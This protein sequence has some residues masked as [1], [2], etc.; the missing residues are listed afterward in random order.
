MYL[1]LGAG[2]VLWRNERMK[3]L[4]YDVIVKAVWIIFSIIITYL[5]LA[6]VFSTSFLGE[7][8]IYNSYTKEVELYSG[9]TFFVR[10]AWWL[11]LMVFA[12]CTVVLYFA[13]MNKN[14]QHFEW[15]CGIVI[16]L[17]ML[18][19]LLLASTEPTSDSVKMLRVV[20]EFERGDYSSFE[21]DQY[22]FRYPFQYGIIVFYQMLSQIFGMTNYFAFRFF[23]LIFIILTYY[24]LLKI[25]KLVDG[26]QNIYPFLI[27]VGMAFTPYFFYVTLIYGNI[28][29]FFFSVCSFYF[30][31]KYDKDNN[32]ISIVISILTI[33]LAIIFKSNCKIFF[34]AEVLILCVS[35]LKDRN[36]KKIV[37]QRILIIMCFL[38]GV[39][40]S[41]KLIEHKITDLAGEHVEG[42]PM[43]TWVAMGLCESKAAPGWYNGLSAEL[44]SNNNFEYEATVDDSLD[45]I[46]E[47]IIRSVKDPGYA[48]DFYSRKILSMWNNPQFS[49]LEMISSNSGTIWDYLFKNEGRYIYVWI[50]NLIHTWILI[51][52]FLYAVLSYKTISYK[53]LLLPIS[54]VGGFVFHI[55]WEAKCMYAMPYV[56]LMLPLSI[57]GYMKWSEW[58]KEYK[59]KKRLLKKG[60]LLGVTVVCLLSYTEIFTRIIARDDDT[61]RYD[62]YTR[63]RVIYDREEIY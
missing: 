6:S 14:Y 57:S 32:W 49:S 19:L 47:K 5:M 61:T 53:K 51:G 25:I 33:I 30:F 31:L 38:I 35:I 56:V 9:H 17:F 50:N 13:D 7:V 20:S 4:P 42:M 2:K 28:I 39:G 52:V 63:E 46:H 3:K 58:L 22:M 34:V 29:G 55:F 27:L 48:I 23:N 60:L 43:I 37:W 11:H 12:I 24:F 21:T 59:G 62:T 36:E 40:A 41:S 16:V 1:N 26:F 10:D 44:Y 15:V 54:I 18:T 45:F 8:E